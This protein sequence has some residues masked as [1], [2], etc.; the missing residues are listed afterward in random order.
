MFDYFGILVSIILGLALTHLLRGIAKQILMR[1]SVHLYWVHVL[2]TVN[3]IVVVLALWWGMYWWK[4]L[5]DWPAP[6]FFFL[7]LYAITLFLWAF[8]LYPQEFGEQT[9]FFV[10]FYQ[11]RKWFFGMLVAAMLLDIPE[12]LGKQWWNLRAV[13]AEYPY[14]IGSLLGIGTIGL[15]STPFPRTVELRL[16]T[17]DLVWPLY[18]AF[19]DCGTVRGSRTSPPV[20]RR[21]SD[22][23]DGSLVRV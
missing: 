23:F 4:G 13:P 2:W 20:L 11:Q 8:M 1:H 6:W 15:G 22:T 7:S 19:A 9:N 17:S 18:D 12:T 21:E 16:R 10:H 14:L 5:S 3:V